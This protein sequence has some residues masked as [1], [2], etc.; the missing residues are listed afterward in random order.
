MLLHPPIIIVLERVCCVRCARSTIYSMP[1]MPR[2]TASIEPAAGA[3]TMPARADDEELVC[4][5]EAA[6]SVA[7]ELESVVVPEEDSVVLSDDEEEDVLVVLAVA[8]LCEDCLSP[9]SV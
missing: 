3:L 6:V 5:A 2:T 1:K 8:L 4:E 7:E 9:P